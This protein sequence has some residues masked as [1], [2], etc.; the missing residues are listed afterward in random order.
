MVNIDTVYQKVLAIANKEQRGYITP[1]EFNLLAD[2]TQKEIFD[3]YFHDAKTAYHK[4]KNAIGVAFDNVE[5][6]QEKLQPIIKSSTITTT[7]GDNVI[8]L[9]SNSYYTD[10]LT[11]VGGAELVEITYK[12]ALLRES[13]PL[14]KATLSRPTYYRTPSSSTSVRSVTVLPVPVVDTSYSHVYYA[15]LNSSATF[16]P[17]WGYV[18]INDNALYNANTSNNFAL[19]ASEEELIVNRILQLSGIIVQDVGLIQVGGQ[20]VDKL[21]A[22]QNN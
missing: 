18:V 22:E 1:Q 7:A 12:E 3:S 8:S 11:I 21:K 2:K 17:K 19:H 13:N 16:T 9:S 14:T 20:E 6:L 5:I 4:P 10:A 15:D